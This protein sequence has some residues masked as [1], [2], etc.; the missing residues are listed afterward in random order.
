MKLKFWQRTY[1]IV[2]LLFLF[3]LFAGIFSL[4]AVSYRK[5]ISENERSCSGEMSY[6]S[7]SFEKDYNSL[8][9]FGKGTDISLLMTSYCEHYLK[10]ENVRLCFKKDGNIFYSSFGDEFL[11]IDK[12]IIRYRRKENGK[13]LLISSSICNGSYTIIYGKDINDIISSFRNL[14]VI[15]LSVG[16][17]ISSIVAVFLFI[18]LKKLSAPIEKLKNATDKIAK[19]DRSTRADES[20]NDEFSSLARS[21]NGMLDEL[22]G[23]IAYSEKQANEKQMLVDNL[24][25]EIRTPLT[26]IK[27]YASY[28]A[29]SPLDEKE[30]TD[31][32]LCIISETNRLSKISEKILDAAYLSHNDIKKEK[33]EL[34]ELLEETKKQLSLIAMKNGVEIETDIEKCTVFGDRELLSILFYNLTENAIKACFQ[35]G[36]VILGAR[37]GYAFVEDNGKGITKEQLSHITEPFYRTDKSRSRAEGGAG[38]GLTLCSRIIKAHGGE[39]LFES[40]I[41]KGTKIILFFGTLRQIRNNSETVKGHTENEKQETSEF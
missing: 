9:E 20:G 36:V 6:I 4:T 17:V 30:K 27:G 18:I 5:I 19:G 31:A 34:S 22:N 26:T 21:F 14:T 15:Y 41:G 12:D 2:L 11:E 33:V 8:L 10:N 1:I 38:L 40:E 24:A 16:V 28:I 3:G 13:E 32:L 23:Q 7:S 29:S 35:G 39:M 37:N 25:H